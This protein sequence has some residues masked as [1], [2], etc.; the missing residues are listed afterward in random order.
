MAFREEGK[1]FFYMTGR[2]IK[3]NK[4]NSERKSLA[5]A[6]ISSAAL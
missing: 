2:K 3:G 1:K 6:I 5:A 4:P